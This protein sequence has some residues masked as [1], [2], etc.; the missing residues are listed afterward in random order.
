M[1]TIPARTAALLLAG[2]AACAG[3]PPPAPDA[4]AHR[5]EVEAW[6][7][8][9]D[10]TLREP[11]GWLSL[12]GLYWLQDGDN[13]F[14]RAAD[15]DFVYDGEGVPDR[16][17]TFVLDDDGVRFRPAPDA[18]VTLDGDVVPPTPLASDATGE[19]DVLALGSLRWYVID[20]G[21][22]LG[23]RLKDRDSPVLAGFD[24]V[25]NY[26]IDQA[27][28]LP[29]RFDR[30]WT[31][32]TIQ[33]PNILGTVS[34]TESPAA[35]VFELDG[36]TYRLD[37]WKDSDDL[38][39][40]F[41]AFGDATNGGETYGGGRFLW[42]DAPDDDGWTVVDFN[43]AYNPPCVFTPFATCP[44]PPRQNRLEVAVQA[45]ERMWGE[46]H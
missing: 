26:P 40:F 17:G 21:G 41:T 8:R 28:R 39:N 31:G 22:R 30:H 3:E 4:A 27:W 7:A 36:E 45:G 33:I 38:A 1:T 5:A 37:L 29:A 9:R 20:R 44:L 10:S 35:V 13:T 16:L 32:K 6:R 43:R 11:E 15:N 46:G 24:G 12:V 34:E 25:P 42:I 18:D 2:L 14:G 23:I 19:P